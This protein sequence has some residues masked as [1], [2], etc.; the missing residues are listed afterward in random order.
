[1]VLL[2]AMAL[3][4]AAAFAAMGLDK[5]RARNGGRRVS[6]RTLLLLAALLGAPGAYAGMMVFR[7]KTRHMRFAIGLPALSAVELILVGFFL[8]SGW[9]ARV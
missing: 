2:C 7:H 8:F 3:M 4:S 9:P 5:L 6:E 1:M